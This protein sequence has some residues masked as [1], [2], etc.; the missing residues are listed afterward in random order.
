MSDYLSDH[1]AEVRRAAARIHAHIRRTPTLG[2]DLDP[3][4]RLKAECF[5]LTGSFKVRGAFN[6]VLSQ[7]E[8]RPPPIGV[9]AVSSGNHAQAV[10]LAAS[11]VGLP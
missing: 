2:T 8:R 1:A 3:D 7:M 4:L 10:A 9:I 5:Q 6:A 11:T